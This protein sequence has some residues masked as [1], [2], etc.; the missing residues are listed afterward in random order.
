MVSWKAGS[1]QRRPA[2]ETLGF[3]GAFVAEDGV[4]KVPFKIHENRKWHP[5]QT[6]HKNSALGPS[7]NGSRERF[8][9]N[10]KKQ[11]KHYQKINCFS[12]SKTSE[13]KLKNIFFFLILGH[14]N[15]Q[16]KN[17]PKRVPKSH[18]KSIEN[19]H[20]ALKDRFIARFGLILE[21]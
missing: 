15:K 20:G 21:K 16:W 7:R 3:F 9:Q 12:W 10:M 1:R 19:D 11:W 8:W 17:D 4:Q 6:F 2:Q 18:P 14:S 5:N 13:N